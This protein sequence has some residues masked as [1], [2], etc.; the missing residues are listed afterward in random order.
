MK[1]KNYSLL[2]VGI[3]AGVLVASNT[4]DY[5]KVVR[6]ERQ[7]R[8]QIKAWE[9]E[10]IRCIAKSSNH[11]YEQIERGVRGEE[12]LKLIKDESEFLN[13][14]YRQPKY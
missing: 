7:K 4:A 10:A 12:L 6:N 13:I 2:A 3:C 8:K 9:R 11:I 14:V 1:N 5:L